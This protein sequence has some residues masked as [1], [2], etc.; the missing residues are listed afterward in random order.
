V[1]SGAEAALGSRRL[2]C[3]RLFI[4]TCRAL[5]DAVHG[6]INQDKNLRPSWLTSYMRGWRSYFGFC[7]T[8]EVLDYLTRWVRLRFRA[9]C[10]GSGKNH[11]VARTLCWH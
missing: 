3:N 1:D 8:P 7:E 5:H 2:A 6:S 4:W 11:V 10:G 9:A